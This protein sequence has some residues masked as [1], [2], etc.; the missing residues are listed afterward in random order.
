MPNKRAS[1]EIVDFKADTSE[2]HLGEFEALVSVFN[3]V[4]LMGDRVMPGAFTNSLAK[5]EESGDPIPVYWSHDWGRPQSNLGAVTSAHESEKGL[6]VNAKLDIADNPDAAYVFKLLQQRRVKEF[7][8]AYR[9][10]GERKGKDGANELTDLDIL[11]VG[12]T[13]KGANPETE[14]LATKQGVTLHENAA[15][16]IAAYDAKAGAR[17]SA[18][19]QSEM[20]AIHDGMN[21]LTARMRALMGTA[22]ED[23]PKNDEFAGALPDVTNVQELAAALDTKSEDE[24]PPTAKSEE[25]EQLDELPTPQMAALDGDLLAIQL[26][27]AEMRQ[28]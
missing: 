10:N 1:Y 9:I 27:I 3:N 25:P 15:L 17:L 12:P 16:L 21:S 11:E 8:F 13:F 5:Y 23:P 24:A 26:R 4:D 28:P 22:S 20:Q 6:V 14:L 2:G 18:A 19:T 7:S